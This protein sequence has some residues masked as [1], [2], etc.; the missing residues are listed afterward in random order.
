VDQARSGNTYLL[1]NGQTLHHWSD[2]PQGPQ[3]L[4]HNSKYKVTDKYA[5]VREF[6]LSPDDVEANIVDCENHKFRAGGLDHN[7]QICAQIFPLKNPSLGPVKSSLRGGRAGVIQPSRDPSPSGSQQQ[8]PAQEQQHE[9]GQHQQQ[10]QEPLQQDLRRRGRS[11]GVDSNSE[12]YTPEGLQRQQQQQSSGGSAR[13]GRASVRVQL[14]AA[15]SCGALPPPNPLPAW[16]QGYVGH[17]HHVN[18]GKQVRA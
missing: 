14:P 12:E 3:E 2:F 9:L 7:K 8:G 6:S 15:P 11:S 4:A 1:A 10:Q 5:V 17:D 16:L 18:K 13:R